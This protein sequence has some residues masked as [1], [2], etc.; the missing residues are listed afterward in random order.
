MP[1]AKVPKYWHCGCTSDLETINAIIV[2]TN[3]TNLVLVVK[4]SWITG[5]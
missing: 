3:Q 5:A 1:D 2:S 4:L